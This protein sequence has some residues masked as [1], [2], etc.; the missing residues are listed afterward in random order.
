MWS[1]DPSQEVGTSS[2]GSVPSQW[3]PL[4]PS[5][6]LF[7]GNPSQ[8]LGY[9]IW[10]GHPRLKGC[11]VR[12]PCLGESLGGAWR[13][14]GP[15]NPLLAPG[16]GSLIPKEGLLSSSASAPS[17]SLPHS[18]CR[19]EFFPGLGVLVVFA[20]EE[21]ETWGGVKSSWESYTAVKLSPPPSEQNRGNRKGA[22]DMG[23]FGRPWPPPP[24][25][26]IC[27]EAAQTQLCSLVLP[28]L[29]A[30]DSHLTNCGKDV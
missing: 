17:L 3:D 28:P 12:T 13:S 16:L 8:D 14:S 10:S 2:P 24:L 22:E 26:P 15:Q 19:G 23:I 11:V 29:G 4:T 7:P 30:G 20:G 21:E 1:S 5:K 18:V 27:Q 6:K 25:L 9:P